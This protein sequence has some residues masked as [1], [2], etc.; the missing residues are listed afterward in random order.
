MTVTDLVDS[1]KKMFVAENQ[2]KKPV[3]KSL[4]QKHLENVDINMWEMLS[5]R[6][7]MG[8]TIMDC[9]MSALRNPDSNVGLYAPDVEA[10]DKFK[11][12]FYPVISD[13][14]KVDANTIRAFHNLGDPSKLVDLEKKLAMGVV[15]TRV[16]VGRS[17]DG[18]PLASKLTPSQRLELERTYYSLVDMTEKEKKKMID[19]HFLYGD[20]NDRFLRDA[21]GYEDWP[22]GRG[23]FMNNAKNFIVWVNEEDH[24]RIISMEKGASLK[25]VYG[26]LVRAITVMEKKLKFSKHERFGYLTFCPTN[27]GTALRASVHAKFPKLAAAGKLDSMCAKLDMQPRGVHGEHTES[28]G[29][30]YDVSNKIRMG[31][32]EWDLI[33]GMWN[34]V[35]KLLE[36]EQKM[37]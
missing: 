30:V 1:V 21:G 24:I 4:V 32:T 8:S 31:R 23:I 37:K 6:T 16:R 12:I 7:K 25:S 9:C 36:E 35:K 34:G 33:N 15:S 13:Y 11:E 17:V 2:M 5:R 27:I 3:K 18:Y 20:G 26:R 29:G 19:D 10:Y 14:H 28:V 22:N